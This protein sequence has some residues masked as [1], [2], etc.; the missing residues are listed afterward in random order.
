MSEPGDTRLKIHLQTL[1]REE[2]QDDLGVLI[3]GLKQLEEP[4]PP[5]VTAALVQDLFRTAHS[6]KGAAH[7]AGVTAAVR[8]CS[9]LE[10]R[11]AAVRGGD[12]QVDEDFLRV[13]ATE[14]ATLAEVGEQLSGN[15]S[16]QAA[17]S[18]AGQSGMVARPTSAAPSAGRA[19]VAVR[20]LDELVH[21][22][23]ALVSVTD[24]LRVMVEYLAVLGQTTGGPLG[25][26]LSDFNSLERALG[27]AV[28]EISATAQRL[29]M[30]SVDDVVAGLDDSVREL[31]R[32][33]GKQARLV[34][35][36]GEVE[37]DRD[38]ADA[39]REPLLHL[40]R[41][42]VGHGIES[43]EGRTAA[44]KS[45]SGAVRVSA[46]LDGARV[47]ITVTDDGSGLDLASLRSAAGATPFQPE[48]P[49]ELAF[50]P[51]V[52]TAASVT[53]VSG[54]G[55]GLDAVR[56]RIEALGG[57]VRLRSTS[58]VGTEAV[59][60]VPTTLAVIQV[61]LVRVAGELIGLPVAAI[62]RLHRVSAD[63]M[64]VL[65]GR[66]AVVTGDETTPAVALGAA[67]ALSQP[68]SS[69]RSMT[70]VRLTGEDTLLLVDAVEGDREALLQPLP[71]RV[72]GNRMFLGAI[73]LDHDRVALVVNP[74][75]CV[76]ESATLASAPN[77]PVV[78]RPAVRSA[79]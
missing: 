48:D 6:L 57:S 2:L 76:R 74:S 25:M 75:T 68:G 72:S 47:R 79:V 10:E 77:G 12:S 69:R 7:S 36:G 22:A 23:G 20:A 14:V 55:I 19:R 51:G 4:P 31:C 11:L 9:R 34:I 16:P 50:L 32:S 45:S 21:Q 61:V 49:T 60:H 3:E 73:V 33:T 64:Q 65:D 8:P 63:E 1:F 46:V 39:V 58:G 78:L 5:D 43:P 67:L 59:V 71:A 35:E 42:A 13:F 54:R 38:V 24:D 28:G 29:R 62:D 70:A 56:A 44:G 27:R 53:D 26:I 18:G 17:P 37:L 52:S 40:V 41:N 15:P 30:Q 66:L